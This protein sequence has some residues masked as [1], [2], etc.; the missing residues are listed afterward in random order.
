MKF[1][2]ELR[3]GPPK[4]GKT[5]AVIGS[6]PK[7]MLVFLFDKGGLDVIPS[8]PSTGKLDMLLDVT[9]NDL[10]FIKPDEIIA[11]CK[12]KTEDL[13]KVTVVDFTLTRKLQMTEKFEPISDA[14]PYNAYYQAI[15]YLVT[16]GCPWKTF[17]LDSVTTLCD[18]L[19]SLVAEKN[20]SW[21]SDARKWSPAVGGK[22]LQ[23]VAVMANLNMHVVFIAHSHMEKNEL[24]GDISI[25]PLGPNRLSEQIG[26]LV[27]QYIYAT[28]ETGSL[29]VWT[30]PKG[31]VKAIGI[32]W[33]SDLPTVVKADFKSIYG[34]EL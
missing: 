6:Y 9:F 18:T 4:S 25:I 20:T 12:K 29:E 2:R 31:N 34:G 15:N 26:S 33:P 13:P 23:N 30:K 14:A 3:M 17:V 8:K 16:I 28:S 22:V 11:Y 1:I 27:S 5:V 7:P 24:T 32:R 19:M 21:L 10:T